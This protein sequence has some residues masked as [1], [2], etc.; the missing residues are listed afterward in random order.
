MCLT[1]PTYMSYCENL[2]DRQFIRFQDCHMFCMF[3]SLNIIESHWRSLQII[4]NRWK[5]LKSMILIEIKNHW[6]LGKS[7]QIIEIIEENCKP[8]TSLKII[9]NHC[10]SLRIITNTK[11]SQWTSSKIIGNEFKVFFQ[12]LRNIENQYKSLHKWKSSKSLKMMELRWKVMQLIKTIIGNYW[13]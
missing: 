1:V 6:T 13:K 8:S 7:S 3:K 2:F 10:K 4:N 5:S 9:E 12:A 11:K